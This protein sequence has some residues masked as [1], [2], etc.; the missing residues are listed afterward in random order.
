VRDVD[1]AVRDSGD[2]IPLI[3]GHGLMGSMDQEDA[4]GLFDW[5]SLA[6]DVR[7][8]RYDAR[9]HGRSEATLD[10]KAYH[11]RELARDL[12]A[13][14]DTLGQE[15]SVLGGVSMGC[16]TS[17]HAAVASPE[18]THALVLA[19]PPTAWKT[20][21][22]QARIYRFSAAMVE[23]VGLGPFRCLGTLASYSVRDAALA[24]MQR[25]IMGELRRADPR[26]ICAALRGAAASDLP[27]P[28][29]LRNLRVPALVL[30]WPGDPTHPLSTAKRLVELLPNAELHVA[31]TSRDIRGWPARIR[32]F[33]ASPVTKHGSRAE[34]ER[35]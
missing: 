10:P 21:P 30:A 24:G 19:G 22:R 4:G 13:V 6:G 1:L 34:S 25:S 15:L 33:L 5:E 31:Q 2:G 17:L 26:A 14:A 12:R 9:G 11:W 18:R 35:S 29:A 3:W 32:E 8:V 16:A 27:E 20:R 28:S 23:R 7:L